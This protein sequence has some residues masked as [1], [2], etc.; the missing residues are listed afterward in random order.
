MSSPWFS[1]VHETDADEAQAHTTPSVRLDH[2]PRSGFALRVQRRRRARRFG[3]GPVAVRGWSGW[4]DVDGLVEITASSGRSEAED[5]VAEA[6]HEVA[7]LTV[8]IAVAG[9]VPSPGDGNR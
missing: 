3:K 1:D 5:V 8:A 2:A 6:R 7:G 9:A 4:G